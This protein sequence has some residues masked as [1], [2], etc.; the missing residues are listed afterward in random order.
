MYAGGNASRG[1]NIRSREYFARPYSKIEEDNRRKEENG[2]FP[3]GC[4]TLK[5]KVWH[6]FGHLMDSVVGISSDIRIQNAISRSKDLGI[7]LSGYAYESLQAGMCREVFAE[8]VSEAKCSPS[9][10]KM[11]V[12]IWNMAEKVIQEWRKKK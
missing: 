9:P 11:A 12:D 8:A 10:R 7:D 1:I 4:H 6:E 3:K 5:A 2:R